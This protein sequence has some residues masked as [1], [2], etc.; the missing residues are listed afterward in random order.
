[1]RVRLI[2]LCCVV[3]LLTL[4]VVGVR[5]MGQTSTD[6]DAL[7]RDPAATSTRS[8][9]PST[10]EQPDPDRTLADGFVVHRLQPGEKPPQFIVVSFDGVGWDEKWQ[11]L[12]RASRTQVPF[13]FT[14]FLSGTYLLS[15]DETKDRYQPPYY[16]AG[17]SQINWNTAADLPVEI[18]DLNRALRGRERDRHPFQRA[19]LC[20][21]RSTVRAATPGRLRSGTASSTS[22][23]T[24]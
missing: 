18:A 3:M 15:S 7:V 11:L 22:S 12:V 2:V 8:P 20:G 23:S 16:R 10:S 1:M 24:C 19:L 13:R 5:L 17:T 9:T 14:G 4:A 21:R 6:P